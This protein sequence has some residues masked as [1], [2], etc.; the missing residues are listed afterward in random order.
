MQSID[1]TQD[2]IQ[3]LQREIEQSIDGAVYFDQL[4]RQLYSTDASN[5]RLVPTGVVIPRNIDDIIAVIEVANR[6]G[7]SLVPRGSGSSLA[8]QAIGP[9]IVLDYSRYMNHILEINME[10]RWAR[11]EAGVVL[12]RLNAALYSHGL[13]VGPD[14]ASAA[15][16]TLGGMTGNNST[17]SHSIK[18]GMM[19]NH[20]RGVDVVL[21]DGSRT[22]FGPK[23]PSEVETLSKQAT[24]EGKLYREIP[25][26]IENYRADI[27]AGYPSTWRNVA[28]YNLN[29]I[30]ADQEAGRSFNLAPLIV[31]SEGTLANIVSVEVGLVPR[32]PQTCLM[33]L[34]FDDLGTAMEKVPVI[35]EERPLAVELTDRTIIRLARNHTQFASRVNRFVEGDPAAILIVEFAGDE[36]SYLASQAETLEKKLRRHGYKLPIIHCVTPDEINNVWLVRKESSGLLSSQPG[37]VKRLPFVDDPAVPIEALPDYVVE[38]EQACHEAGTEVNFNSHASAGCLHMNPALNLKT[39]EGLSQMQTISKMVMKIAIAHQGTTT[40]EHGEGLA[41]SYYNEQ[42]Y[43]PRLHQAFREV[44]G[45]FDHNNLMNPGKII[46]G[47]DPWEPGL[48]RFNP[49]YKTPQ[50]PQN[51]ILNFSRHGGFTGLVEMCNGQGLCRTRGS[52]TMCPSFRVTSEEIHSTRGRANALRAAM[53]GQLGQDGMTSRELY[54]ALDLCLECKTCKREC[55]VSVDMAK[56]KYEFLAGYQARHGVPLRSWLF[57]HIDL[58]NRIGSFAPLLTNLVYSNTIFRWLLDRTLGIDRRRRLPALAFPTFQY[59]FQRRSVPRATPKRMVILWDDC[60]LSYNSPEIGKAA[61]QLLEAA[62]F[63]VKLIANRHCCGRPLIS[64]GLLN[65][66]RK[67]AAHNV[68]LLAPY[69][70]QGIPIIGLE[71]SCIATLRDEY[72]DLLDTDTAR[73][74]AAHS[75]FIEEFLTDLATHGELNL[76]FDKPEKE[77]HILVHGHCYQKALISTTPLLKMLSLLPNTIVEEI[78]SGCCGMAGSFGYEKEHYKTSLA[79]G[80]EVLLPMVRAASRDTIIAAAGTSCRQ[81]IVEE[82]GRQAVHPISLMAKAMAE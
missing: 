45:L 33:I 8:G 50:A 19:V 58:F 69:A 16:A 62:R 9:G 57:G 74:V 55:S 64:K 25:Q 20:V 54:E 66:A 80:E 36:A 68:S 29:Y 47:P 44:K 32:P 12:D 63:E 21:S 71:P 46:D 7:V 77:R 38:I 39:V 17:G 75:F 51:T 76:A 15:I 14:P 24:L 70:A 72:P 6:H 35:L 78:P 27:A 22:Y 61:V 65:N 79:V 31:G 41:R 40:G 11:V 82:T 56:L 2:Q 28:G 59:W 49:D 3:Y 18:Y 10:G 81:Q 13:M 48:L 52:G 1:A 73:H 67:N 43:G 42:L 53:T 4:S 60:Y 34:H 23:T 26:L 5:Y 37:D 30:L